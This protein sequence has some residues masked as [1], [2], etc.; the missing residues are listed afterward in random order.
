MKYN[1]YQT[2]LKAVSTNGLDIEGNYNQWAVGSSFEAGYRFKMAG[3]GWL[4]PYAQFTW[5][6]VEGKEIKLSN[7]M[8]GD[9]KP[10]ISLRSEVG[11]S[12]GYEFG[13]GRDTSSLAYITAAW[14]RENRDNNHTTINQQHQFTTDLSGNAGKLGFG[15]SSLVSDR[16][17][18]YAEAHYVKGRKT[19]QALQGI[20]GVRYSF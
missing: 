6:Q 4:Q 19:K 5:L 16:L 3:S 10:F 20:L 17:K 14:L 11:L 1:Q 7:E 13:L 15:L 2:N 9:I 18:L 12:L 8:T